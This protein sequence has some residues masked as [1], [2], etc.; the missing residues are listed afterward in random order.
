MTLSTGISANYRTN[1][2]LFMIDQRSE[3]LPVLESGIVARLRQAGV[4]VSES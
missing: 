4:S 3:D 1:A 2:A